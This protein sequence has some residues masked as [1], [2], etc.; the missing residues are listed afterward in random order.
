MY[1]A[2]GQRSVA[3]VEALFAHEAVVP[4]PGLPL[5]R[6]VAADTGRSSLYQA[7]RELKRRPE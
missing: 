4:P 5:R 3:G 2:F 1:E 7:E 6:S